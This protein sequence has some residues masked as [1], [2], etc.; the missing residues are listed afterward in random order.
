MVYY[1]RSVA[2]T[3]IR[4]KFMNRHN[5]FHLEINHHHQS[6]H[7]IYHA[8]SSRCWGGHKCKINKT[9]EESNKGIRKKINVLEVCFR[10]N[11]SPNNFGWSFH[12]FRLWR[13]CIRIT[14]GNSE[15][16]YRFW[17][18][19]YWK[20]VRLDQ[21]ANWITFFHLL[22]KHHRCFWLDL[23]ENRISV[24]SICNVSWTRM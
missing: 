12:R 19:Y 11:S 10:L 20:L 7:K 1:H 24:L 14:P 5:W 4:W 16:K 8:S 21:Y 18:N 9:R 13:W 23:S 17:I 15:I 6:S 3:K 2:L 22:R